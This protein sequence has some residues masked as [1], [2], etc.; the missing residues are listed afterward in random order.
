MYQ[1]NNHV[2]VMPYPGR[3]HLNPLINLCNLLSTHCNR[4]TLFTIILTQEWLTIIESDPNPLTNIQFLTIPNVIPSEI[5]RG[6]DPIG[7]FISA[8]NNM[9]APFV[10]LLDQIE[11]SVNLIIAD[12][13]LKWTIDVANRRNIPVAAY[14]PMSASMFTMW[15]H[16]DLLKKHQHVY[17]DLSERGEEYIDYIPGLSPMKVADFPVV[18]RGLHDILPDL[19]SVSK[20]AQSLLLA[21]IYEL[22]PEAVDA[23]KHKFKIPVY[24]VGSNIPNVRLQPTVPLNE[25]SYISWLDSKPPR[26][27]LYVSLGSYLSVSSTQ[28]DELLAGLKQSEVNFLWVARGEASQLSTNSGSNGLVVQWCDQLRVLSHSSIGGFLTHCGWNSVKESVFSGVPMLTF[29]ITGEQIINSKVIVD[30]WKN[31]IKV[32]SGR[33][34]VK[35]DEIVAVVKRLMNSSSVEM[36]EIME[37]V[38]KLEVVCRE[39]NVEGGSVTKDID[40]FISNSFPASN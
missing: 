38:K 24:T 1:Y 33:N 29:P 11:Q 14:W 34:V 18:D 9:E 7:F 15:Y 3:G 25:H 19:V 10:Q 31:G 28:M 37:R 21:T 30:D 40:C 12:A 2:V 27:V 26:S 13:T 16:V 22:E 39:S 23:I 32:K 20:K 17:V 6:T 35:S 8:Q 4:T 5:N 36:K